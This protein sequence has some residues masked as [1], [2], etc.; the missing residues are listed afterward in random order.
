VEIDVDAYAHLDKKFKGIVTAIANT[1]NQKASPDAVTE[2]QVKIRILNSSYK[3][4]AGNN[5]KPFRPGMT[6][7]VDIITNTKKDII[8]VP[9]GAVTT[10]LPVKEK[11]EGDDDE[12]EE[13]EEYTRGKDEDL[14]EVVF[15]E[16][17]GVAEQ[18]EV[19]TGISDFDNIEIVD[20]LSMDEMVVTGPYLAV[21]KNLEDGDLIK[22]K[23]IK[24]KII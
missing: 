17:D 14:L 16:V 8:S 13:P 9:L 22:E 2:F 4:L 24:I 5:K 12:E 7:S 23:K 20:G 15:V 18:R 21:S 19:K 11:L 10:R 6:A 1:A 3:E